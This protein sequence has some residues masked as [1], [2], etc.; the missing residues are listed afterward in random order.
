MQRRH[1]LNLSGITS[2]AIL[3][4][5]NQKS[6]GMGGN[7]QEPDPRTSSGN[8]ASLSQALPIPTLLRPTTIGGVD[9][10]DLTIQAST[11]QFFEGI[12]TATYGISASYLGQTL[13][14]RNGNEVAINYTNKLSVDTTMHAH[15]LHVPASMDGTAHQ[16]IQPNTTWTA[17]Y[18][19]NQEAS[20]NWYHSHAMHKTAEQVYKGLAGLIII[21]D[22]NSDSLDLPKRYGIDDIPL[23]LQDRA[24]VN[25]QIDYSPSMRETM[26]GYIADTFIANGAIQPSV[27]VE[28]KEIR[29]RILNGSN[30]TIYN[31]GFSDGRAFK[32]I[33]TDGAFLENPVT[34]TRLLLSPAERAEIVI[35]LSQ[36]FNQAL[37]LQEFNYGKTFL[38][39]NINQSANIVTTLPNT[40][41]SLT[42]F[43]PLDAVNTRRFVLGGK[44]GV[45]TIN[46]VAMDMAVINE[47]VPLNQIEIWEIQ[48]DMMIDHNFHI[49]ATHFMLLERNGSSAN[50]LANEKGYKDVALVPA[51]GSIKII[52]KM[53]D[54]SNASV[55]YMYHCHILEHEDAGMMGQFVVV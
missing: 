27:S 55:P 51:N 49:H 29:F 30:A 4:G 31:L 26:R 19:I 2:L 11:H 48:N 3:G 7:M 5:C 37:S 20:T 14:M 8:T 23:V 41:N 35:D 33:A 21:E 44:R 28:A 36:D 50:I 25:G 12:N 34:I 6:G 1:F 42:R 46:S 17:T 54:Y 9:H 24:F 22:D 39:I 45:L 13:L 53:I 40:L 32:Q 16:T 43:N 38:N 10:Y 52:L 18:T 15:G 47:R